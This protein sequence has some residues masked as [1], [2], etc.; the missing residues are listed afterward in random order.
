MK[1]KKSTVD[2]LLMPR[3]NIEAI[4][5][6]CKEET[7]KMTDN[8]EIL[9]RKEEIFKKFSD[10]RGYYPADKKPPQKELKTE[11]FKDLNDIP[12]C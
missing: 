9:R 6:I 10:H 2:V 5:I 11:N 8:A 3:I 12:G 1:L 4:S 7:S